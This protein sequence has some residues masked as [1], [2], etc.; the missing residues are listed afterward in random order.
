MRESLY[1]YCI[2]TGRPRLLDEWDTERNAPLT[3]QA[4]SEPGNRKGTG[5]A[6]RSV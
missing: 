3:P 1:D 2:R 4:A 6:E 5:D